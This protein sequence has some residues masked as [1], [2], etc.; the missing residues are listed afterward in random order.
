MDSG[1]TRLMD[2]Q[3]SSLRG[4]EG[5][6]GTAIGNPPKPN[7]RL[8]WTAKSRRAETAE[9]DVMKHND[10]QGGNSSSHSGQMTLLKPLLWASVSLSYSHVTG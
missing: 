5:T 4:R 6:G 2:V 3:N 9:Y 1:S 8:G 7:T 10:C